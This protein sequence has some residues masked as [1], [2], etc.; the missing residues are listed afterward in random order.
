MI[1]LELINYSLKNLWKSRGRSF[2]TILSIFVGIT[3][4]FIFVSFG[5]GL[6]DYTN[7]FTTGS[8]VDKVVIQ[9]KGI[10]APG[11][12]T[13]FKLTDKDINA[14]EKTAGV[15]EASGA[16]LKAVQVTQKD[17]LVY[18]F[19]ISYDPSSPIIMQL[20]DINVEEG[21]FLR[22]GEKNSVMLG[23][24]YLLSDKIFKE[25]YVLGD[26]IDIDGRN[27][28]IIGFLGA[29]GNPQDDSQIYITNAFAEDIYGK[30]N[31]SY[32]MIVAR[33][34]IN[35]IKETITRIE[36][37][38][39]KER[40]LKVGQEDFYVQS[41]EDLIASF[42]TALSVIIAFVVLIAFISIIVS[43]VN[44]ANTM[45]TSVLERIKEIGIM[46]SVGAT[47]SEIFKIFLFESAFLG[48][49]AGVLGILLG[50]LVSY[51]AGVILKSLG[52]G[53]L[54][55]HFS[56]VL[57]AG[58]VAFATLTGAVSGAWPAWQATKI[59]PVEA[60]RYE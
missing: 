30:D 27:L 36:K 4:I 53:F 7:S 1:S 41:F 45:V 52:W 37:N 8:S 26:R 15:Y 5:W 59:K 46:K 39:R 21:R 42:Q 49:V 11:L 28:K 12:D 17:K 40:N 55:P 34:D 56:I 19:M 9:S 33:V 32:G 60:L 38:L 57:F 25:P 18:T 51:T 22:P 58:C 47:N 54:S 29:V 20:Y 3:T 48:F 13:T 16:Y 31:I 10:T 44:T 2:L 24:N 43:A 35:D 23:Y 14:I 50:W 6:Y